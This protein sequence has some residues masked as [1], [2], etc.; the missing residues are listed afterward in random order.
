MNRFFIGW[1]S[2]LLVFGIQAGALAEGPVK[3]GVVDV[4]EFQEKSIAFQKIRNELQ[5]K[6][7]SLQKKLE[8]EKNALLK[9]EEDY[10]K[11]SMMLSLDAKDDKRNELEKKRRYY[12]Y[13]Y[14]D[15]SE[16]MK[17]AERDATRRILKELE[18]VVQKIADEQ[19]YTLILE[20]SSPGLVFVDSTLNITDQV[21]KAYDRQEQQK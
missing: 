4:K 1:I 18:G 2:F 8:D 7:Q 10:R 3:I 12:K 9:L 11:Q 13:L 17:D 5:S 14:E 21:I 20:R 15:L 16:Q 6:F 19:G